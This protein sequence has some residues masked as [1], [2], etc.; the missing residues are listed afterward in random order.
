MNQIQKP[1][2]L[3]NQG[4]APAA[5]VNV[6]PKEL[7]DEEI[8]AQLDAEEAAEKQA[9]EA[10][11][12]LDAK[13]TEAEIAKEALN[14]KPMGKVE[15]KAKKIKLTPIDVVATEVGFY[16]NRRIKPGDKFKL[17]DETDFSHN[18]MEKI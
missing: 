3:K 9:I 11:K 8:L 5:P 18:W 7:S 12:S 17:E 4:A 1:G 6:P 15:K 2:T 16:A 14:K 13:E 10:Q